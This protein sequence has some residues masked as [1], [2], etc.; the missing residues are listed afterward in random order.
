[1]LTSLARKVYSARLVTDDARFQ[2]Q[3]ARDQV[4]LDKLDKTI[5][6]PE[7]DLRGAMQAEAELLGVAAQLEKINATIAT[8]HIA[9][10]DADLRR[11][12]ALLTVQLADLGA[13]AYQVRVHADPGEVAIIDRL[14]A[15]ISQL[16]DRVSTLDFNVV[17]VDQLA[18]AE[19]RFRELNQEV[20][21]LLPASANRA[22]GAFFGLWGILNRRVT[23]FGGFLGTAGL[24]GSIAIWHILADA[25][26]EFVA[27]LGPA[28]LA[29]AAFAAA[30]SDSARNV[31][32]NIRAIQTV[33][34]ATGIA[35][36]GLGGA[37]MRLERAMAPK[38]YEIYGQVLSVLASRMSEFTRLALGAGGVL[39]Q[40]AARAERA[41]TS[42]SFSQLLAHAITDLAKLGDIAG[43]ILGIFGN[44]IKMISVWAQVLLT[45]VDVATRAIENFT[46]LPVVQAIGRW[47]VGLHGFWVWA[48]LA[49]SA[50]VGLVP[51]LARITGVASEAT[52]AASGLSRFRLAAADI[53]GALAGGLANLKA[54]AAR[55]VTLGGA[56]STAGRGT[57]LLAF[58]LGAVKAIGWGW[59]AIGAVVLGALVVKLITARTAVQQ[60]ADALQATVDKT[61]TWGNITDVAATALA[62]VDKASAAF[63]A[64]INKS[65]GAAK[66]A[67][68]EYGLVGAASENLARQQ[69]DYTAAQTAFAGQLNIVGFRLGSAARQ[70][71]G[72][73]NFM[74][75][76]T[77]AGIKVT[78]FLHA[79]A[80][81]I[82]NDLT[83][84]QG[85][86][87]GYQ[88]MGIGAGA[89]G[90]SVRVLEVT[91]ND[92]ITKVQQLTQAW[93]QFFQIVSGGEGSFVTFAQDMLSANKALAQTGGTPR[94]VT[95]TFNAATTGAARA[96]SAARAAHVAFTGLNAQSLQLRST[97]LTSISAAQ[98]YYNALQ[99]QSAAASDAARGQALLHQAGADLIR[100]L[101]PAA[102]GSDTMKQSI[103]ALAQQ[104]GFSA[105]QMQQFITHAGSVRKNEQDL[106][107]VNDTLARSVSNVGKDWAA[108]ATT[109]QSQVKS[110]LDAVALAQS[111][112]A[113]HAE[114]LYKALH[115]NNFD[116]ART[117]YNLLVDALHNS[118]LTWQQAKD[119]ADAYTKGLHFNIAQILARVSP[120]ASMQRDLAREK[121]LHQQVTTAVDLYT[122]AIKK[123]S[124]STQQGQSARW[125]LIQ[126]LIG[127]GE[128]AHLSW[129]EIEKLI[130]YI[131]HLNHTQVK[132]LMSG[133]GHFSIIGNSNFL[134]NRF[135]G[136]GPGTTGG[137]AP[138]VPAAA[139]GMR[140]PGSGNQDTFPAMLTPGEAVVPKH[141]V[142]HVAPFLAAH[143]VPGFAS[144]GLA[145]SFSGQLVPGVNWI[146]GV[147]DTFKNDMI[148]SM[149]AA[150]KAALAAARAAAVA[151]FRPGPSRFGGSSAALAFA[152]ANLPAGWSW[153]DLFLLWQ[154]ECLT[155]DALILTQR[156]WLAHDE[157]KPGDQTIGYNPAT[158]RSE[159]T[160]IVQVH[161]FAPGPVVRV[162]NQFWSATCTPNH[163]WLMEDVRV[164]TRY[165]PRPE[166][167]ITERSEYVAGESL[168]ETQHRG[169]THRIVL[170]RKAQ[171]SSR[172]SITTQEASLLGWLAGEGWETPGGGWSICQE[173]RQFYSAIDFAC[174][175]D[176]QWW[177]S[178]HPTAGTWNLSRSYSRDLVA[179]AGHPRRDAVAMVLAMSTEQRDA[180]LD[181]MICGEGSWSATK[182]T[183]YQQDGPVADAIELAIYL[184][185]RRPSRS[186]DERHGKVYWA[187]RDTSPLVGGPGRRSFTEDAGERETWCV[188]TGL[189]TWTAQ[190]NRHVF[191]TG[192]SGWNP[193]AVN[194][195]SGAYGIPQ[196]LGHG[197]PF[198]LGDYANQIRW[199]FNYIR[200]RYG[201]SQNAWAHELSAGW[202]DKGGWLP[203]GRSIAYNGTG[204]PER[205]VAPGEGGNITV[206]VNVPAG[207]VMSNPAEV[208]RVL[209]QMVLEHTKRGGR[210]YPIGVSPR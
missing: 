88:Q 199:G 157:V 203:P 9:I 171:T 82:A 106:Q 95:A 146:S 125:R 166:H 70:F 7:I 124:L 28:L 139:A 156:G 48:G 187:I 33:T 161:H 52:L 131:L 26:I 160:P 108:M 50:L 200:G 167:R 21:T 185:G 41:I 126:D 127:I 13:R 18:A 51:V 119:Y 207:A 31:A 77:L 83:Q 172:L 62:K 64:S 193:Y 136:Q 121:L 46:A 69:K 165:S 112:A 56:T 159:W 147:P 202:Y 130:G 61:A 4:L 11:R 158:G 138:G 6:S 150:M 79:N 135:G 151:A 111:G 143:K 97:W 192:N 170:A 71:G 116:Q 186:K 20:G 1:V 162:G 81:A 99:T 39:D 72:L 29:L 189:G 59:V 32:A 27:V 180:W 190:Q 43:N 45:A 128:R 133:Q 78:D 107:K 195:T 16:N 30:A 177:R 208:G 47:I 117:Q 198:A 23:L 142:P 115:A 152:R 102:R 92:Q 73:A 205:V 19:A 174:H 179:R 194:P 8:A 137:G 101:A 12:L 183:V 89:L 164:R 17:G 63:T 90:N 84:I 176:P 76:A 103:F 210:L 153:T 94:T 141:L 197:H 149:E 168:I 113:T 42:S 53:G 201:N 122:S 155:L 114:L 129:G 14:I 5:V 3:L 22:R 184:S 100:I 91:T 44:L 204:R 55:M 74:G 86:V 60:W 96:A 175:A 35:V 105:A 148:T 67:A 109:L 144:G 196:S 87:K 209:G 154:R 191:L 66:G 37:F 75:L 57:R 206:N 58:G 54:W 132:L 24:L 68:V 80:N 123:N 181:A 93:T 188:T 36:N 25:I 65:G 104:F 110:A 40:L 38:V 118:G 2:S 15:G 34:G 145:G 182:L 85:L 98:T 134:G 163:R 169:R 120:A 140:V 178:P 10:D 173:K 49:T